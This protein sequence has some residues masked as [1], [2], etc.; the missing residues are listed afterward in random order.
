MRLLVV[1]DDSTIAEPLRTGLRREGFDVDLV[2]TGAGALAADECD[3]VLLDLGL[4]DLDGRVVCTCLRERSNVPIIV[5][6]ARGEEIDRVTLLELGADDYVVKPFGFRELVAR[7][8][9]VL[10]RTAARAS[11]PR[12]EAIRIEIGLLQIDTRT[13]AVTLRRPARRADAQGARSSRLPRARARRRPRPRADHRRRVGPELVGL[14]QDP[15]RAHRFAAQEARPRSHRDRA[16]CRVPPRRHHRLSVTRR[17]LLSYLTITAIV[18]LALEVP[19]GLFFQ[20]R[21][22]DRL[23]VGVERDATALASRYED[24]LERETALDPALAA[25]LRQAHRRARRG[26][27]QGRHLAGRYVRRRPSRLLRLAPRSGP[28][29]AASAPRARGI[30]P[31]STPTS[32]TWPC[33]SP[34][35]ARCSAPFA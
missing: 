24:A 23:T 17:L 6:T 15:R 4:P 32:C 31:R 13:R 9:A 21:Q 11:A 29:S 18:L 1:E 19:L 26:R 25:E 27:R 7:I 22:T 5:V 2:G 30:P 14:H 3:L 34:R 8:R 33:R 28:R 16:R 35:A 10:R 20:Q 12:H